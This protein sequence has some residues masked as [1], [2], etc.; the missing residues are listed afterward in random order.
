[1]KHYCVAIQ[2]KAIE[3]YFHVTQF[4]AQHFVK[5]N[6]GNFSF[7][8]AS[9]EKMNVMRSIHSLG[10]IMTRMALGG[11]QDPWGLTQQDEAGA[12]QETEID[13]VVMETKAKIIEIL[14]FIMNVRLD[15]RISSLLTIF[16]R[17]FDESNAGL[18]EM[19]GENGI[20][21]RIIFVTKIKYHGAGLT[22]TPNGL[23]KKNVLITS[24]PNKRA[25]K[26]NIV[27]SATGSRGS[28]FDLCDII[29]PYRRACLMLSCVGLS[30]S[31]HYANPAGNTFRFAKGNKRKANEARSAE[32]KKRL[33][34]TA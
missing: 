31:D 15:Y 1:M 18:A 26:I 17:D 9:G 21:I 29:D 8:A 4:V 19:N 14:E 23:E 7:L 5:L 32:K 13:H 10:A 28:K 6:L 3:R 20:V 27:G 33:L 12:T 11:N 22:R 25:L 16:K 34:L 2:M 30:L 24:V